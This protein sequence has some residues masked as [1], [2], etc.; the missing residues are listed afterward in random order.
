MTPKTLSSALVIALLVTFSCN[1]DKKQTTQ[2]SEIESTEMNTPITG[3]NSQNALDWD[4][5]YQGTIPCADCEGIAMVLVLNQNLSYVHKTKYLGKSDSIYESTGSFKWNESGSDITLIGNDN[6]RIQFKVGENQ[7]FMLDQEGQRITGDLAETYILKKDTIDIVE[8]Y[9]KLVELNGNPVETKEGQR[10]AFLILKTED[11]RVHGNGGCNTF[12][13]S[14]EIQEANR[15][16]F[17]KM[18][19]TLMA[20]PEME[21]EQQFINIIEMADNYNATETMLILNKARMAPLAKFEV[22]YFK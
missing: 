3:D 16:Q 18:A 7:L 8:K 9:W 14:Y 10:E 21:T 15:I 4:G 13:G 12:N 22:V 6:T 2:D 19:T 1:S 17:S 11:T 20:C 5:V